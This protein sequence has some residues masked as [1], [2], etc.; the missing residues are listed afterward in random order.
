M[1]SFVSVN[2]FTEKQLATFPIL[3]NKQIESVLEKADAAQK[4]WKIVGVNDR[5]RL[6][7]KLA[8]IIKQ[9]AEQLAALA[10]VEMGKPFAEGKAEV[11]KCARGC[12]YYAGHAA[13]ILQTQISKIENEKE[14]QIVFEPMGIVLGIFPWNFP[15]WQIIRSATPV[16]I[17]GNAMLV[18]P[19]PNTPQCALA[20]QRIIDEAGFPEGV[21]QTIFVDENQ[22]ENIISDK[23]IKACTLTG[24]EKAGSI[25]ASTAAKHI[26]KAVLELGGSDPFLVLDDANID[27]AV[28][29]AIIGRFQNN[30]QSCIAAKRFILHQKVANE[31]IEKLTKKVSV[32][33]VGDPI[34]TEVNIGPLARKDLLEKL[35]KQVDDSL[36]S[37]AKIIFQQKEIPATGFF[38]PPTILSEIPEN[39]PA[40]SEE[41]FGPVLSVFI[42][43]DENE[44]INI[45]NDTSF[46]LGS[47]V[48]TTNIEHGKKLASEIESGN[49]FINAVVKS[50]PRFPFGGVKHSGFGREL[51]EYG[52]KEFCNIKTIQF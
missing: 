42:A 5:A 27:K 4:K 20:M 13:H 41:L 25:V 12:E 50:D 51:G 6:F 37:G 1:S 52:L 23:R 9:N 34:K 31:F 19:S 15:Y 32:L 28:D 48:W 22:I 29:G 16:V 43:N 7:L 2:P 11:L 36:K 21:I 18:K 33:K 44:M 8:E 24:S 39:S 14:V 40:Y 17:A 30:G 47:S 3:S 26:K 45:A 46:G 10:T 38:Y 49:V 35:K